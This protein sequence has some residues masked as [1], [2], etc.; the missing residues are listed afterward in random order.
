[1]FRRSCRR[2]MLG[3]FLVWIFAS[4]M[5][6]YYLNSADSSNSFADNSDNGGGGGF[7]PA[8]IRRA[9]AESI[10]KK[11]RAKNIDIVITRQ[12]AADSQ[13]SSASQEQQVMWT[14]FDWKAYVAGGAWHAGE[15]K[16]A[17]NKFNQQVSDSVSAIRDVP[18]TRE[19][20]C[21]SIQYDSTDLPDTSVVITFHNEA[22]STLVRTVLSVFRMSPYHLVR[23]IIL[24][25]DFST[26]ED[27]GKLLTQIAKVRLIRNN[28]REGL[29]RSRIRGANAAT[30]HVL[31]FLDSHCECN[32]DWLQPLLS[33][34]KSDRK[35]VVS[36]IIDVIG[37]DN[38]DYIG[39]SANLKGGFAWNLVFKW[40]N[41]NS[42]ELAARTRDPTAPI[43]TPMI[44][45]GLFSIERQLFNEL[46]QYDTKMDVWGAENLEFS[47]R[48]WQC[49]C[50]L[51]ILP[52]SR[53]G[54]VFRRQHPYS[55]PGGSGVVFTR[56]TRR[57][58]E[59][60]LDEYKQ[61]YFQASGGARYIQ[62][63]DVSERLELRRRLNCRS[64]KW[65]LENV[66]PDLKPPSAPLTKRGELRQGEKCLDR[67][68]ASVGSAPAMYPCHGSG[69]NQEWLFSDSGQITSSDL[70]L[71]AMS[72]TPDAR[73]LFSRCEINNA[74]QQFQFNPPNTLIRLKASPA[75]CLDTKP[76]DGASLQNPR[77][78]S[79]IAEGKFQQWSIKWAPNM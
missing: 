21:R 35:A 31:T 25:D 65:Y 56:N 44:A 18:D 68:T 14:N 5:Y 46:G 33:R 48:V 27:T 42:R 17:K 45:G 53:V 2:W 41:L 23:E 62:P 36:P 67:L 13:A 1:M 54:H 71:Q 7:G 63:G 32:K 69:G 77:L 22:R 49:H 60:W 40:D 4:A 11:D 38:F 51:E 58:A 61:F 10:D 20:Q 64:F 9:K 57:A 52:C 55:F 66:Y 70:C 34:I 16:Y 47:L 79:C 24:V 30:G 50:V 26:D 6:F 39:A 3:F 78:H 74:M 43:R 15:D 76:I 59:V 28:R 73:V 8:S 75:L 12:Q 29:M 19:S 37:M 72:A